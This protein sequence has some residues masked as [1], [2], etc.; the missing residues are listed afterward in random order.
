MKTY[1]QMEVVS[2]EATFDFFFFWVQNIPHW[3]IIT[4]LFWALSYG[5]MWP[6]KHSNYLSALPQT[7]FPMAL[8]FNLC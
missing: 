5:Y 8:H 2:R 1:S 3:T 4:M 7:D 6:I